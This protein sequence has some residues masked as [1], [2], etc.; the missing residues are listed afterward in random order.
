[1][2]GGHS[3]G[4]RGAGAP[5]SAVSRFVPRVRLLHQQTSVE[6]TDQ[7]RELGVLKNR[8]AVAGASELDSPQSFYGKLPANH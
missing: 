5:A 1:M 3:F 4:R 2:R 7:Q 8:V 6:V